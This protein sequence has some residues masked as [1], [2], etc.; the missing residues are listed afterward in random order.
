M[1]IKLGLIETSDN[2]LEKNILLIGLT[3]KNS[4]IMHRER[5]YRL[6]MNLKS[7]NN[8]MKELNCEE[9]TVLITCNRV[10]LYLVT[11]NIQITLN[12]F[13][14]LLEKYSMKELENYFYI[15]RNQEVVEHIFLVCS[16]LDSLVLGEPQIQEQVKKA[17]KQEIS[18]KNSKGVLSSLFSSSLN[19][20]IKIRKKF[21]IGA[22]EKSIGDLVSNLVS[23]KLHDRKI[24]CVIFGFG[25]MGKLIAEKILS[26]TDN[27]YIATRNK[28]KQN[29]FRGAKLINYFEAKEILKNAE[30]II[31]STISDEY[32]LSYKDLN[33]NIKRIVIDLGMPRNV[34]PTISLLNNVEY[35]DLDTIAKMGRKYL[36]E[37]SFDFNSAE[38]EL[39]KEAAKFY[40]WLVIAKLS[41]VVA[42]ISKYL[43]T[44]RIKEIEKFKSKLL[45]N[46]EENAALVDLITK[47]LINK[48]LYEILSYLKSNDDL[49][50]EKR[51]MT[52]KKIFKNHQNFD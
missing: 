31:T 18:L 11:K 43:E 49:S 7:N 13:E 37:V 1:G 28:P 22:T 48:I 51:L 5:F 30:L 38:E 8:I 14:R 45:K 21:N 34:E 50:L 35:Y 46:G 10:E 27:V 40:E 24:N 36:S 6:L 33:D 9:S 16:G 19:T 42:N 47:R 44:L 20:A 12:N 23:Q 52:V 25:A 15:L 3:F 2:L 29:Y 4:S 32:L 41:N 26:I 17:W 39:K